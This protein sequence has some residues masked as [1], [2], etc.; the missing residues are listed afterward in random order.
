MD[1]LKRALSELVL[2]PMSMTMIAAAITF[3]VV[4]R[5]FH[6]RNHENARDEQI[7]ALSPLAAG[8]GGRVTGLD[9]G[10][11]TAWSAGVLEPLLTHVEAPTTAKL[12]RRS[13]KQFD[14]ALDF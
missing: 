7:A 11:T 5:W 10:D 12:F 14:L 9:S 2:N 4:R 3:V 1:I 6:F 8:F 13:K